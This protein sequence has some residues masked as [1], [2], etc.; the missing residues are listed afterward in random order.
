MRNEPKLIQQ[1]PAGI[2]T[3][4]RSTVFCLSK[5]RPIA[6]LGFRKMLFLLCNH[7]LVRAGDSNPV[8]QTNPTYKLTSLNCTVLGLYLA[9]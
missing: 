7:A 4:A 8:L 6:Y 2:Q 5:D 1:A 9:T 3:N